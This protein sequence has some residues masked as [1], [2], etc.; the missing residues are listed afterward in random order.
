[1]LL[2]SR[3][4]SIL[5]E[6]IFTILVRISFLTNRD[7]MLTRF[8][9]DIVAELIRV[10]KSDIADLGSVSALSVSIPESNRLSYW[11]TDSALNELSLEFSDL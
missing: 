10:I 8:D 6:L 11:D 2:A 3:F 1:M 4:F 7:V 5:E 9:V